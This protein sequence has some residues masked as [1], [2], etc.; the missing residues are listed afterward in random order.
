MKA[1]LAGNEQ[2]RSVPT[3]QHGRVL[4]QDLAPVVVLAFSHDKNRGLKEK[5]WQEEGHGKD[6][7]WAL[8]APA[9]ASGG[10]SGGGGDGG[11]GRRRWR[12]RPVAAAAGAGAGS[13]GRER[14][15]G[16]RRRRG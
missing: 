8:G 9:A 12:R 1:V 10:A 2:Q 16:P 7:H 13:G 3:Q 4:E 11:A 14:A 5:H 6:R 15:G